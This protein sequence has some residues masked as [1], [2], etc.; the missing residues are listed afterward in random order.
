M[1]TILQMCGGKT[2]SDGSALS[3]PSSSCHPQGQGHSLTSKVA[4]GQGFRGRLEPIILT[5]LRAEPW[6]LFCQM[7]MVCKSPQHR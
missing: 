3:C 5:T 2:A 7:G 1:A 4:L 6:G